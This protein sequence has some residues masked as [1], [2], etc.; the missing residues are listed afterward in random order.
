MKP[1]SS[2][3][4]LYISLLCLFTVSSNAQGFKFPSVASKA[5]EY[6]FT[7]LEIIDTSNDS[8]YVEGEEAKAQL[9]NLYFLLNLEKEEFCECESKKFKPQTCVEVHGL[10]K[11]N[12]N[13]F[14]I[15]H[16]RFA[17]GVNEK[18]KITLHPSKGAFTWTRESLPIMGIGVYKHVE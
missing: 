6:K 13:I 15:Y 1:I 16:P 2:Q 11:E 4:F 18:S 17:D 7:V 10:I 12:E 3:R 14:I 5:S 8:S 9:V